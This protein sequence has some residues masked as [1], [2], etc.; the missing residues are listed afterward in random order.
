MYEH[1]TMTNDMKNKNSTST[2]NA[3]PEFEKKSYRYGNQTKHN[4]KITA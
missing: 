3:T 4:R 1:M 2:S